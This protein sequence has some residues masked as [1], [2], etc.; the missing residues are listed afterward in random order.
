VTPP[1]DADP[2]GAPGTTTTGT[3]PAGP[4]PGPAPTGPVLRPAATVMLVRDA[5]EPDRDGRALE[6]LMVRRNLQSDFVG[7]AYVFPGGAVDL[8]DGGA[9][10]EAACQGRSDAE[11]SILLGVGTGGLA[12]WVAALR[13]TFEE[14]GLLLAERP[15]GPPLLAGDPAEEARFIAERAAVNARTRRFLDLCRDEGLRLLVGD[16]HYFAHWITPMGAPRRYDTRF[17]VAAAPPGQRAAHDAGETIAETWITPGRALEG[18][19]RGEFEIIFPTIRNLQ[20]IGRFATSR[21]LLDAAEAASRSVPTIEPHVVADGNGV[22]IV[23][24][25]DDGY[26]EG[27]ADRPPAPAADFNEAVRAVSRAAN[28]E[29][30][31][32]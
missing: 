31:P 17:F 7:G 5:A 21:E 15:A 23:L 6:V 12:Y 1:A 27:G 26:E 24:P 8:V 25:G 22:R 19:R 3:N 16:V 2:A 30:P 4:G 18:H 14:A 11:A 13:E 20:A 9:E 28:P 32:S 29:V 10:A